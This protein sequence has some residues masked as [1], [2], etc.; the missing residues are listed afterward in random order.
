M[1]FCM[2]SPQV[3]VHTARVTAQVAMRASGL[4]AGPRAVPGAPK[5]LQAPPPPSRLTLRERPDSGRGGPPGVLAAYGC[6]GNVL[7]PAPTQSPSPSKLFRPPRSLPRRPA[8][9]LFT[10]SCRL[11][12]PREHPPLASLHHTAATARPCDGSR[13]QVA[14]LFCSLL[15]SSLFWVQKEQPRRRHPPSRGRQANR[16]RDGRAAPSPPRGPP[17]GRQAVWSRPRATHPLVGV[18]PPATAP[19]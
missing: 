6:S 15:H 19:P 9:Q 4:C 1:F 16:L 5:P 7:S 18:V 12:L 14:V 2:A 13:R 11:P 3:H 10:Y 8:Q 17:R